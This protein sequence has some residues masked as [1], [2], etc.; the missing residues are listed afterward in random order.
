M[1]NPLPHLFLLMEPQTSPLRTACRLEKSQDINK[2]THSIQTLYYSIVMKKR[3][4]NLKCLCET[5]DIA[6]CKGMRREPQ[7]FPFK[8]TNITILN[9]L[10]FL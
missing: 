7:L 8:L 10:R 3:L 1:C 6:E 9:V 2:Q 4:F 5:D